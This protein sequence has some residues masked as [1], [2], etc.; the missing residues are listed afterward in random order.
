M[1]PLPRGA[2]SKGPRS[3]LVVGWSPRT[4]DVCFTAGPGCPPASEVALFDEPWSSARCGR[5]SLAVE[6]PEGT[7]GVP[8][9]WR[10]NDGELLW[11]AFSN[12]IR[13]DRGHFQLA[14]G[15]RLDL[16]EWG[17]PPSGVDRP[18]PLLVSHVRDNFWYPGARCSAGGLRNDQARGRASCPPAVAS[19]TRESG[20]GRMPKCSPN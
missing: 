6:F 16:G 11:R 2:S 15:L 18:S 17:S 3:C 10:S 4:A 14:G 19:S 7:A 20:P 13:I 9:T 8:C 1:A 12:T 5:A